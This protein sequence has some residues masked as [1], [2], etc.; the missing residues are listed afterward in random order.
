MNPAAKAGTERLLELA[1]VIDGHAHWWRFPLQEPVKGFLGAGPVFIVG[2]QPSKSQWRSDHPNRRAFYALLEKIG[3]SNFHLTDLY[4]RRGEPEE[5]KACLPPIL[6][7]LPPDYPEHLNFF[8]NEVELLRP[9]R[10]VALGNLAQTLLSLHLPDLRPIRRMWHFS[11]A[12]AHGK[13][14]EYEEN[15]RRAIWG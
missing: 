3:A 7:P 10:I 5:L 11:Y 6:K 2:D 4:K 1:A 9:T 15:M 8:R 12:V 14:D 13:L